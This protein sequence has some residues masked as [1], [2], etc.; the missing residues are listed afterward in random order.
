MCISSLTHSNLALVI[1][2]AVD[3][4]LFQSPITRSQLQSM[5]ISSSQEKATPKKQ[6]KTIPKSCEFAG[7]DIIA[8][9][10]ILKIRKLRPRMSSGQ[11][12]RLEVTTQPELKFSPFFTPRAPSRDIQRGL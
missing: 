2:S 12:H 5:E 1:L 8:H 7:T 3:F 9:T 10:L 6:N 11:G 4:T